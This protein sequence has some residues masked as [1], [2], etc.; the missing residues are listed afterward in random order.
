MNKKEKEERGFLSSRTEE[1]TRT[2]KVT[3][4]VVH[5]FSVK[6]LVYVSP[7]KFGVQTAN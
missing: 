7:Q 4:G 5:K 3:D 2:N 1:E 6:D